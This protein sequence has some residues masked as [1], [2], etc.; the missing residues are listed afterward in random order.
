MNWQMLRLLFIHSIMKGR[1]SKQM[2]F[3]L[4]YPHTPAKVKF[5]KGII[6]KTHILNLIKNLY[7]QKQ[8]GRVWNNYLR[9][10]LSEKGFVPSKWDPCLYYQR[11]VSLL[12]YID[13][14]VMFSPMEKELNKVMEEMR[15]S[16][17]KFKVEDLGNAKDFLGIQVCKY[18][19][20]TIELTQPKLIESILQDL[21]FQA[22]T[23]MKEIPALSTVILQKDIKGEDFNKDIHYW[24]VIRKLKFLE[25][26]TRPDISYAIHQ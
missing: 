26:S 4:A 3:I 14:C 2:D 10:G 24:S 25:K 19:D 12:E 20:R 22:N 15:N 16:S 6:K 13:D 23:K 5:K 18:K 21:N 11:K 7:G 8:A 9:K 17:R 1:Y